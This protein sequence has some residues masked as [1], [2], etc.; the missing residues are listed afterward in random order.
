MTS[1]SLPLR[2]P[3]RDRD[4]RMKVSTTSKYCHGEGLE[5]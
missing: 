2:E 4:F 3:Q 5:P 1:Y